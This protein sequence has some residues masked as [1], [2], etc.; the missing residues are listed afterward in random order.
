MAMKTMKYYIMLLIWAVAA[1]SCDPDGVDCAKFDV[2]V[3]NGGTVTAGQ[4][5]VF[6]FNGNADYLT[7]YSGCPENNY[8]NRN[9][10][11]AEL[12]ALKM[13]CTIRQ[14]YNDRDYL[15]REIF[16]IYLSTDFSGIYTPEEIS[17]AT[18]IPI[19]GKEYHRLPVPVP[20]SAS[21]VET[22]GNIDLSTFVG[23]EQNFYIAFL[24]KA[25]GRAS[26]PQSNGSGRYT[27]RPRIDVSNLN[28]LKLTADGQEVNLNNAVT[29]WG[30]RPVYQQSVNNKNYQVNDN[31][32]LFQPQKAEVDA[33]TG[34]EPDE[35][36]WMV[37]TLI[38]P[39]AVEPDRGTAI[40]SMEANLSS[41][42]YTYKTPGTYTATFVA[43]NANL[44]NGNQ[45]VKQVT[46]NVI[47]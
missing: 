41:Y 30:F 18:W 19:S 20:T 34:R 27:N 10:T 38:R 23:L 21:P 44:W 7:F 40:K 14:Q 36:V 11:E 25:P 32:L 22:S 15:N 42:A 29:G 45:I 2:T 5:A 9:R 35:T 13:S 1:A 28:M 8:D 24:Y 16:F 43:T 37:S 26:I 17:K 31:G 12:T 3:L 39:K 46:V 47:P 33:T 6:L 4:N